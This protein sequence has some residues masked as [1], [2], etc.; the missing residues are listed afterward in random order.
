MTTTVKITSSENDSI[1]INVKAA[2]RSALLKNAMKDYPEDSMIPLPDVKTKSLKKIVE[3]LEHY[4]NEDPKPFPKPLDAYNPKFPDKYNEY[5]SEWDKTYL[6]TFTDDKEFFFELINAAFY[7]EIT[8]L[9][10]LLGTKLLWMMISKDNP[11]EIRE[12]LG[13]GDDDKLGPEELKELEEL[14]L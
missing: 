14:G 10:D 3:F 7:M 13:L 11:E 1:T 9:Q 2:E 5:I 4:E 8:A 12:F 6:E